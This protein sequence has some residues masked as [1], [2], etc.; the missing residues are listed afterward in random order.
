V[1]KTSVRVGDRTLELSNL[2]KVLYPA[3]G[4]TK[5]D[6]IDY[7]HRIAEYMLP[8]IAGRPIT[9]K[10]YPD[11]VDGKFFY[12]KECPVHRPAWVDTVGVGE[13]DVDFCVLEDAAGLVWMANLASLELHPLL[14]RENDLERPTLL[15]FDLDPGPPATLLECLEVGLRLRELLAEQGLECFPKT[16]GGKGLHIQAPLNTPVTFE[17]TKPFAHATALLLQKRMPRLVTANMRTAVRRGRVLVDWSQ[18]DRHKS[19]VAPYSLRA[20]ERPRVSTP[21]TW[22]EVESA[23]ASKDAAAL[24]FEARDVLARV[25]KR[26]DL[27][28]PVA[29]TRQRLPKLDTA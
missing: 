18:N 17:D 29:E 1:S 12:Q 7:Y 21:V 9:M 6:V 11:G 22:E 27:F 28:R 13:G 19:T 24:V 2:D 16:S 10:R 23:L 3:A 25:E 8:H 20:R 5:A 4:F 14:V 15:V 26:G